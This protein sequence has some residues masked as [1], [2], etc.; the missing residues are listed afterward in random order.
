MAHSDL[1]TEAEEF[2]AGHGL[3]HLPR[4][5]FDA[6]ASA[7]RYHRLGKSGVLLMEDRNDPT[8]FR[9]FLAVSSHLNRLGLSAPK[10]LESDTSTGLALIE[11]FGDT[12]YANCMRAGEDETGL[13]RLAVETL[14]HLHHDTSTT[15][16]AQPNY[17]LNV[18]LDELSIFSQWFAPAVA[19]GLDVQAFDKDFRALWRPV[20]TPVANRF[21][22]LVL[23][24]FHI[25]NLMHLRGRSGVMR[26]GLLDFQDAILGPCEYDL[27]SLLQDARRDLGAGLEEGMLA[28]YCAD[29]PHHLGS[30]KDI[31]QRYAILGAQ[32]HARI[33]GVFVRLYQQNAKPRYLPFMPRVLRQFQTALLDAGLG[34]VT[35]FL[36]Q[37]LPGWAKEAQRFVDRETQTRL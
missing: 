29:A 33:L 20:L 31:R 36:D 34:Q 30:A 7:R 10:V 4:Q 13:Y 24:D 14:L 23:R 19:P 11:D 28:L 6:D 16:I 21:E 35:D 25:D 2:L 22:T 18:H 26:C 12:T 3:S 37:R 15:K 8:A 9:A 17:D 32:R 5:L 1:D 27:V